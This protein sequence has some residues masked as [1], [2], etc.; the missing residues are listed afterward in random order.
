MNEVKKVGAPLGSKNRQIGEEPKTSTVYIKTMPMN[1]SNWVRAAR[2][3]KKNSQ[4]LW[5]K[6]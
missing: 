6:F 3:Q 2:S 4:N 1:K 5:R